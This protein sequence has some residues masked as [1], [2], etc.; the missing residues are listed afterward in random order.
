MSRCTL[1]SSGG[2]GPDVTRTS[3]VFDL[4]EGKRRRFALAQFPSV[5]VANISEPKTGVR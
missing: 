5:V 2:R 1:I 4:G 3:L